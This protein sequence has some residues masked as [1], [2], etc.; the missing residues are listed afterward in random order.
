MYPLIVPSSLELQ[1]RSSQGKWRNL[2]VLMPCISAFILLP[3]L[4]P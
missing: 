4:C 2:V 3:L 1:P